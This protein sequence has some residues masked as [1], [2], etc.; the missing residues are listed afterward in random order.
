MY[1]HVQRLEM[2]SGCIA[3]NDNIG[4]MEVFTGNK[5]S[6][7]SMSLRSLHAQIR[8]SFMWEE[9]WEVEVTFEVFRSYYKRTF[10]RR[11]VKSSTQLVYRSILVSDASDGVCTA[12]LHQFFQFFRRTTEPDRLL[13]VFDVVRHPMWRHTTW[14]A[15]FRSAQVSMTTLSFYD[16][17]ELAELLVYFAEDH[18]VC[19]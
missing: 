16:T 10:V 14:L 6:R 17:A 2:T 3:W 15:R 7:P 18:S 1:G 8:T 19:L 12:R 5:N 4:K 13:V 11:D 9:S